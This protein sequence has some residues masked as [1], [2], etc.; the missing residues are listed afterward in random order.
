MYKAE[1][2]VK[3]KGLEPNL[4]LAKANRNFAFFY[5]WLKPAIS[6]RK[7]PAEAGGNS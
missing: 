4:I 6:D 7:P 3:Q 1:V 2:S 5:F